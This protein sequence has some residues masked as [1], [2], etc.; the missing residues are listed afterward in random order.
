VLLYLKNKAQRKKTNP[1]VYKVET[2]SGILEFLNDPDIP[3]LA[4]QF[5]TETEMN[6]KWRLVFSVAKPYL[7]LLTSEVPEFRVMGAWLLAH[8]SLTGRTFPHPFSC[9][10]YLSLLSLLSYRCVIIFSK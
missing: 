5:A 8:I 7:P 1:Q 10:V 4:Y 2:E 6:V 3:K 9:P